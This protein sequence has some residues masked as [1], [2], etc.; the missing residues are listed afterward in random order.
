MFT[1]SFLAWSSSPRRP[2]APRLGEDDRSPAGAWGVGAAGVGVGGGGRRRVDRAGGRDARAS[3][4]ASRRGAGRRSRG[5]LPS[6]R[7]RSVDRPVS[8]QRLLDRAKRAGPGR[9]GKPDAI[10]NVIYENYDV[11]SSL[12]QD[13]K[14][15]RIMSRFLALRVLLA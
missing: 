11:Y 10:T 1:P 15:F 12:L 13:A 8:T 4:A 2:L 5:S 3:D 6:G 7:G 9:A 14:A